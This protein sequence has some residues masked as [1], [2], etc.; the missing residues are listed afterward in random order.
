MKKLS[1]LSA[2]SVVLLALTLPLL[3]Q[4]PYAAPNVHTNVGPR[5]SGML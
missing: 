2:G 5:P 3:A 4:A 1:I